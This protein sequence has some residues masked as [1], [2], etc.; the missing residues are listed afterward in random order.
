[1]TIACVG[2]WL[3]GQYQSIFK[4]N[5][6]IDGEEELYVE[7]PTGTNYQGLL[8]ILEDGNV[9][10]DL[11]SFEWIADIR[12]LPKHVHAGRYRILPGTSNYELINIFR[13]GAQQPVKLVLQPTRTREMVAAR[14]SRQ[15]E[16]DSISISRLLYDRDMLMEYGLGLDT[17][18]TVL[19]PN[20]YELYWNTSAEQFLKR[21]VT[22]HERFWNEERMAKARKLNL[23]TE[24]VSTLASIVQQETVKKDEQATIAGVYLNRIRLGMKLDADPTLIFAVGDFTIT[25]VLN[26]HKGIDSPYNTY[27]YAGLPPG[28]ICIPTISNIDAVLK[29]ERH[30]YIYFCAREDFSGYHNFARTLG[31][32]QINAARFR[33]ELNRRR[34]WN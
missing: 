1:M 17:W 2:Y 3:Y 14:V 10:M 33:R 34:I 19:I 27:K 22:E 12:N 31:Q 8:E 20:T 15:I 16:A 4:G 13:S 21:M 32:H 25:R 11:E 30:K 7:I 23:T 26:E 5:V 6:N 28:P 18:M 9:L 24:E 29:D